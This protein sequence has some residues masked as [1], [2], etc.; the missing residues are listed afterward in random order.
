MRR[1][2]ILLGLGLLMAPE[3]AQASG[4]SVAHFASEHRVPDDLEPDR[5]VLQP[6][7]ADAQ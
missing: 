2:V 4:F 6:G 3:V 7:R 1:L 5:A